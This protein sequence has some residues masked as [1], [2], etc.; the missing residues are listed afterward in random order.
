MAG[1]ADAIP[2]PAT[3]DNPR[4]PTAAASL[5]NDRVTICGHLPSDL[6]PDFGGREHQFTGTNGKRASREDWD[7]RVAAKSPGGRAGILSGHGRPHQAVCLTA[8]PQK[9]MPPTRNLAVDLYRVSGVVLIVLGHWLAGSVT[10][11]DGYFGR[12]NPLVDPPW[13][14]WLTWP[15]QAVPTFF[16]AAG[17]A[18]AVSW[19][20]RHATE[21]ESRQTWLRHRLARR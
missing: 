17:Y 16:L 6:P 10:Y 21:G 20:H 7:S 1:S 13:T 5:V 18:A 8:P 11:H 19:G 14:Q 12:Q 4:P 15:F 9:L 2:A 3:N